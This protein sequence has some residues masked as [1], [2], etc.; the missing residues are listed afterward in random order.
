MS[1]ICSVVD[2]GIDVTHVSQLMTWPDGEL[3]SIGR[4]KGQDSFSFLGGKGRRL[5][6]C[7][8]V[9]M[10]KVTVGGKK[11]ALVVL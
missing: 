8:L 1:R 5:K 2:V 9:M 10:M 3:V 11:G 6:Y 4:E 7:R